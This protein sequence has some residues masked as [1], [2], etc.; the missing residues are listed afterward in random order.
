[1]YPDHKGEG[2]VN[3]EPSQPLLDLLNAHAVGFK[4]SLSFRVWSHPPYP[5]ADSWGVA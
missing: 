2:T 4:W 3:G 1:M 5:V